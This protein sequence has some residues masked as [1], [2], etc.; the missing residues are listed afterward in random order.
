MNAPMRRAVGWLGIVG[1][2]IV[3]ANGCVGD[4][5]NTVVSGNDGGADAASDSGMADA[6]VSAT[7]SGTDASAGSDASPG[8]DSGGAADAGPACDPSKPFA[9]PTV[10]AKVNSGSNDTNPR[11]S[12][13]ELTMYFTSDRP[14]LGGT[15]IY[16]A[17][18]ASPAADFGAPS[19]V[20]SLSSDQNDESAFV[21]ADGKTAFVGSARGRTDGVG[22]VYTATRS[23][24]GVDFGVL[25][26]VTMINSGE[27]DASPFLD[28]ARGV[29][30]FESNRPSYA[31]DDLYFATSTGGAF[32]VPNPIAEL[33]T[34][35]N[36]YMPVIDSTGLTLYFASN[37]TGSAGID[38]WVATRPTTSAVFGTPTNAGDVAAL[39]SAVEDRPGWVSP[40][41]CRMY[42]TSA[43]T[44][45]TGALDIWIAK[46][47]K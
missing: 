10:L 43:R 19:L 33:N 5:G 28:E 32:N 39:N 3:S 11:L 9:A 40:D 20:T 29:L 13:D 15:D 30:F 12:P 31:N 38:V 22:D 25:A 42:F 35:S 4:N 41:G 37:R 47:P 2:V 26:Q 45:T 34:T 27:N 24:T 17:T 6:G 1:I 21:T 16:V 23:M 14:G 44:G 36:E 8:V 7:D 46:R 18:R